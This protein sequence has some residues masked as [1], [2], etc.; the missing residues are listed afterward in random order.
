MRLYEPAPQLRSQRSLGGKRSVSQCGDDEGPKSWTRA[1]E[2]LAL[3]LS[4][5]LGDSVRIDRDA[6]DNLF[7]GWELITNLKKSEPQRSANL[8]NEL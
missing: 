5:C 7:D 4:V 6:S 3:Q 1:D 8:L 2:A